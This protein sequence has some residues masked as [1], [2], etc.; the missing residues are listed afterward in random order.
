M[1]VASNPT[2]LSSLTEKQEAP[3][4]SFFFRLHSGSE[5]QLH[6][7]GHMRSKCHEIIK[8]SKLDTATTDSL[9]EKVDQQLDALD[10]S[11]G[12]KSIGIF[13]SAAQAM[14][15]LYYTYMPE[16]QY[17]GEYFSCL[18]SLYAEQESS[19]YIVFHFEPREVQVFKG[20]GDHL[21]TAA[22]S[23]AIEHLMTVLK[24]REATHADKDGKTAKG[25]VNSKWT[26]VLLDAM[27]AVCSS[28]SSNLPAAVVGSSLVGITENDLEQASMKVVALIEEVQHATGGGYLSELGNKVLE[29]AHERKC[30]NLLEKCDSAVSSHKLACGTDEML[31]CAKEGRAETLIL[32]IPD[33]EKS[34]LMEFAPVH[35]IARETLSKNGSVEFVRTNALAK[36]NGQAMILRY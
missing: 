32:H 17:K 12:A 13:I 34:G 3:A 35:E 31:N 22:S 30:K 10:L 20:C 1:T 27:S 2:K 25:E 18:E 24:H 23:Q 26:R 15:E 7:A 6:D 36:W 19:P 8:D 14:S 4:F 33:W 21:E 11:S 9:L 5:K 28:Y 29:M 16:R